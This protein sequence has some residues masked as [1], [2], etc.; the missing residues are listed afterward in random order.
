MRLPAIVRPRGRHRAQHGPELAVL[1]E[2]A[3]TYAPAWCPECTRRVDHHLAPDGSQ[4]CTGCG[5]I[6]EGAS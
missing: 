1:P 3:D 4:M 5:H 6:T 2:H